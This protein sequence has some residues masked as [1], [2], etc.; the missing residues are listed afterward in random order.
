MLHLLSHLFQRG[1]HRSISA[2]TDQSVLHAT[3][4]RIQNILA[5]IEAG[6]DFGDFSLDGLREWVEQ[7][8]GKRIEFVPLRFAPAVYG[9]WL[10]VASRDVIFYDADAL[11]LHQVHIQLH[12]MSHILCGHNT[13]DISEQISLQSLAQLFNSAVDQ[14]DDGEPT[15]GVVGSLLLR[16]PRTTPEELEAELLSEW[17]L[18][19]VS[20]RQFHAIL[21]QP[22][23]FSPLAVEVYEA[24]GMA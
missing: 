4:P 5:E 13:I 2:S 12:E 20:E 11:P 6:Y 24:M 10:Q 23:T 1:N 16:S 19:R 3:E 18:E 14:L 7:K 15:D 21:T 9:G 22:I 17:I 8:R